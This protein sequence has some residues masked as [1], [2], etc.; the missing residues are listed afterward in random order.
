MYA[1]IRLQQAHAHQQQLRDEATTYRLARGAQKR[2]DP[3]V[4]TERFPRT[5]GALRRLVGTMA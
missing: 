5:I 3:S 1:E 4:K 2:Y